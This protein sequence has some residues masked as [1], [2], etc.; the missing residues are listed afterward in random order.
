MTA[1]GPASLDAAAGSFAR[2]FQSL[3]GQWRLQKSMSGGQN[4]VGTALFARLAADCLRLTESGVLTLP[5]SQ[6]QAGRT[7]DWFLRADGQLDIRYPREQGGAPYHLLTPVRDGATWSGQASH[8]CAADV[9][10]ADYRLGEKAVLIE[11]WVRGPNK[12][13]RVRAQFSR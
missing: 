10:E 8:L 7:W 4:F 13:Y 6:L 1:G 12:H 5:D 3:E 2:L 11:H 9:Y